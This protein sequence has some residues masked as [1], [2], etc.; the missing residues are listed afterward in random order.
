MERV[1]GKS[2]APCDVFDFSSEKDVPASAKVE[3][4]HRVLIGRI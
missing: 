3:K 2:T 4:S 1:T